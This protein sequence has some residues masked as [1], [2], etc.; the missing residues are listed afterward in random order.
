[1][2]GTARAAV[3]I[4]SQTLSTWRTDPIFAAACQGALETA[5]D[6]LEEEVIRRGRDGWDE[7]QFNREGVAVGT[8]RRYSDNLL[9]NALRAARPDRYGIRVSQQN[10]NMTLADLEAKSDDELAAI[11]KRFAGSG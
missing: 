2:I 10:I 8:I 4:S 3:N 5:A 6:K 9:L 1:M 11:L 7:V